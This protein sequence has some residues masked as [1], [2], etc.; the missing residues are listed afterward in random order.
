MRGDGIG[1]TV[2]IRINNG[3]SFSRITVGNGY[4]KTKK[5]YRENGRIKDVRITTNTGIN[6]MM[7]LVDQ[8]G[9]LPIYL[10]ESTEHKWVKLEIL[11]VYRGSCYRDTFLDF[12]MPDFEYDEQLLQSRQAPPDVPKSTP[13][14][15]VPRARLRLAP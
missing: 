2:T 11:S 4:G 12:V 5:S 1:Q 10:P 14:P 6:T 3:S 7:R 8:N 9:A 13:E 15:V